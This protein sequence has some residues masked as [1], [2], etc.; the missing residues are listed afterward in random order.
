MNWWEELTDEDLIDRGWKKWSEGQ[1]DGTFGNFCWEHPDFSNLFDN[2]GARRIEAMKRGEFVEVKDEADAISREFLE[3]VDKI[4]EWFLKLEEGLDSLID[5]LTE[6][7][8]ATEEERQE[9]FRAVWEK[10]RAY[11]ALLT[12]HKGAEDEPVSQ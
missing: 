7:E 12:E 8:F 1:P 3:N 6:A 9:V 2:N 4:G 10:V 11:R 5:T